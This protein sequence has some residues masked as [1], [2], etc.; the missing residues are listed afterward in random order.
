MRLYAWALTILYNESPT[1][2]KNAHHKL[3]EAVFAAY[4]WPADLSDDDL[5]AWLLDLD[6]ARAA[7]Q[8]TIAPSD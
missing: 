1:W 5:L 6:L 8:D 4:G 2:L 7:A 3:D